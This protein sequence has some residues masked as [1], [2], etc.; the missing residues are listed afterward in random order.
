ME[1]KNY[2]D[3]VEQLSEIVTT[4]DEAEVRPVF[5]GEEQSMAH[6]GIWNLGTDSLSVIASD[7]YSL[8]NHQAAFG[9]LAHGLEGKNFY[10]QV[11]NFHDYVSCNV[12]FP[13][14]KIKDDADGID[15]G[16]KVVNS[17][18]RSA[19]FKGYAT[20]MRL[21]CSNGMYL[22][23]IIPDLQFSY[24]HV[25]DLDNSVGPILDGFFN[26][27][28]QSTTVVQATIAQARKD[29]VVFESEEQ[30]EATF[31]E[32]LRSPVHAKKLMPYYDPKSFLKPSKWEFYNA[33]TAYVS[34]A[35]VVPSRVEI[36][37]NWAEKVLLPEYEIKPVSL[38][39]SSNDDQAAAMA[40]SE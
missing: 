23:R 28:D 7:N 15:L 4:L 24:I 35:E 11:H 5:V 37:S 40:G 14:L 21:V 10:G 18:N 19:S 33:I 8:V 6:Q 22:R 29:K 16:M 1:P 12:F 36:Y 30:V 38:E 25:G 2:F 9:L 26:A 3:S 32:I 31:S 17:Y 20:A 39:L 34:H 27:L 13:D